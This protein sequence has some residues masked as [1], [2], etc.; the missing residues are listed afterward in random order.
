MYI[1]LRSAMD[2][3]GNESVGVVALSWVACFDGWTCLD[4]LQRLGDE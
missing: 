2:Y 1:V 4:I 3:S